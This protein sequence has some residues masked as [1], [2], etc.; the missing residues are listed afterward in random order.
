MTF[1]TI[2]IPDV[3]KV[4]HAVLFASYE[5]RCLV[6]PKLLQELGY[7]GPVTI[8]YCEDALTTEVRASIS[9]MQALFPSK[10]ILRAVSVSDPVPAIYSGQAL[11]GNRSVIVDVTCFTRENLFT[12]LW[13]WR[14]GWDSKPHIIFGYCPAEKYGPWLT[15]DFEHPHNI[16]G[17]GGFAGFQPVRNLLCLVGFDADRA[18]KMIEYLEP[19]RTILGLGSN[20]TRSEFVEQNSSAVRAVSA[21]Q[22]GEIRELPVSDPEATVGHLIELIGSLGDPKTISVAPFNNKLSCLATYFVWLSNRDL[23][24]CNVIP[25]S[26]NHLSYSA[27]FLAPIFFGVEW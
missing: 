18:L 19:T 17:F 3:G 25:K 8:L 16:V 20:P 15:R 24:I 10:A 26:Y 22:G 2:S 23:R 14:L 11:K 5:P 1:S 6:L 4:A 13:G 21:Q 7:E 27:G 9:A 12:L